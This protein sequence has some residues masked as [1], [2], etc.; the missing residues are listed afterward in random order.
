MK[1]FLICFSIIVCSFLAA[2]GVGY[3]K[4]DVDMAFGL[5]SILAGQLTDETGTGLV[6]FNNSPTFVDDITIAAAGVLA[7]GSNGA[8]TLLGLGT[9][10]DEDIK[11]DLD[12]TAN[13]PTIT[14]STG[15]NLLLLSAIQHIS[16][17]PTAETIEAAA[18]I[19]ANA[20]GGFKQITADGVVTTNTTNTFTAPAAANSG[21]VMAVCNTG[22]TNNITL[23]ANANFKS[24]AGAD[25]LL[26]PADCVIVAS[27]GTAWYQPS[28]VNVAA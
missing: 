2:L 27:N 10:S 7:T 14:S 9:G 20:C 16:S 26:T 12:T 15:A 11:I 8:L 28:A 3:S 5:S 4:S 6:V 21:C 17:P 13:T 24:T 23:D 18:T 25:V 22:A 1:N 19:T